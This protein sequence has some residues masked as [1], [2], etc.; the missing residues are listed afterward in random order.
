LS[1][2]WTNSVKISDS[3]MVTDIIISTPNGTGY[4]FEGVFNNSAAGL[5]YGMNSSHMGSATPAGANILFQDIHVDWRNFR[6]AQQWLNWTSSR[7]IWF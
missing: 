2:T 7:Q 6:N 4:T 3:E 5:P 1:V